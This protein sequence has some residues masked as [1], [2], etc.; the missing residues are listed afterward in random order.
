MWTSTYK[1]RPVTRCKEGCRRQPPGKPG[2]YLMHNGCGFGILCYSF[3]S[4]FVHF[5]QEV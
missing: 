3:Y 2:G 5:N 4:D 1:L